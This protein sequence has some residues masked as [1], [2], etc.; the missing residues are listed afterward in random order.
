[1]ALMPLNLFPNGLLLAII[2]I[3]VFD[4]LLAVPVGI[5]LYEER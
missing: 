3:G 5:W 2:G 4:L 1:M